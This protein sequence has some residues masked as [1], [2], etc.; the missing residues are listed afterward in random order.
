MLEDKKIM[1]VLFPS[2]PNNPSSQDLVREEASNKARSSGSRKWR[3][4]SILFFVNLINYMDRFTVAGILESIKDDYGI[5]DAKAGALQ[6][7]FVVTYMFFAPLFGYLGDRHSRRIIMAVGVFIWAI[8]TLIGSFMPVSWKQARERLLKRKK[9]GS[10]PPHWIAIQ[11][12]HCLALRV[13]YFL[14]D[15]AYLY[16]KQ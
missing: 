3:Y 2:F 15:Y 8:F 1:Q 6:T 5:G 4:V 14:L 10:N 12:T 7:A 11:K 9:E 13:R 16:P